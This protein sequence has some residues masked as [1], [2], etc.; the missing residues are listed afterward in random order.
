MNNEPQGDIGNLAD[1]ACP[2]CSCYP[3]Q[4]EDLGN[5][6]YPFRK[7]RAMTDKTTEQISIVV[8]HEDASD[9][10]SRS[11]FESNAQHVA[12][13]IKTC[14]QHHRTTVNYIGPACPFCLVLDDLDFTRRDLE[15]AIQQLTA[16]RGE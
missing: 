6:G 8:S 5:E 16:Q 3:C 11:H 15:R 2:D 14:L 7:E 9:S 12:Q 13:D 10:S 4:C 1:M